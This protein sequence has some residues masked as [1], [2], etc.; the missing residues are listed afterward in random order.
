MDKHLLQI[1]GDVET[2]KTPMYLDFAIPGSKPPSSSSRHLSI[3]WRAVH[4]DPRPSINLIY[5][6]I[7]AT[8]G[9]ICL[10]IRNSR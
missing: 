3:V 10:K 6:A 5:V 1:A 9:C 2:A 8:S 4:I 7:A